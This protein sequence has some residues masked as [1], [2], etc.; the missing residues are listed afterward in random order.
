MR[1]GEEDR[2]PQ[3]IPELHEAMI[4]EFFSPDERACP[5]IELIDLKMKRSTDAHIIK[6][7]E[8]VELT[9]TPMKESHILSSRVYPP[10]ISRSSTRYIRLVPLK[11]E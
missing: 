11:L 10:N 2:K 7:K 5:K 8:L 4:Q 9:G 3:C 1:S 6:I